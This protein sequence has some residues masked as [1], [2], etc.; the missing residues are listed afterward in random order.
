M[1]RYATF[2]LDADLSSLSASERAMVPLLI[3]AA[4]A[5]EGVYW[6][7]AYGNPDDFLASIDDADT[8]RY[9]E[10]NYGPWDRLEGDAPF[11]PGVG[12][13]PLGAGFYPPDV[14]KE[15][16]LG[17]D[18]ADALRGLYSLVR[19]HRGRRARGGSVSPGI[20]RPP[21]SSPPRSCVQLP[22]SPSKAVSKPTSALVPRPSRPT[23]TG[24]ATWHG[25][26]CV[27]TRSIS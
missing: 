2:R 18:N 7:Q 10:V 11:L 9:A 25:W 4:Q 23:T 6:Q 8:R 3:E 17:A 5:M 15:E 24:P 14:T 13:K 21:T 26:T 12:P 22:T 27:T 1:N 19:A 16:I 20:R